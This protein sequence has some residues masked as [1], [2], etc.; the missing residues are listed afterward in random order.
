MLS[1]SRVLPTVA[2]RAMVVGPSMRSTG[3]SVPSATK[4]MY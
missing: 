4:A 2:A 1:I 3:V